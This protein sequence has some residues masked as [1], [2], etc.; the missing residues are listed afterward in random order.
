MR[1]VRTK[2]TSANGNAGSMTAQTSRSD[3]V[4]KVC[5]YIRSNPSEDLSLPALEKWFGVSRFKIQRTFKEIMGI[6][7]RKYAEE[8]RILLLKKNL[9]DNQPIPKAIYQSGYNS[10]SW[11]YDQPSS[12]LG[13][14]PS[15]YRKGGEGA[16]INYLTSKCKLGYLLVAETESGIC[17]LSLADKEDSLVSSLFKEYP[18]AKIVRSESVRKRLDSVLDYFDGQLLSLPVDVTG[19]DFQK[20]VWTALLKIPYGETRSYQDVAKMIGKPKAVRAVANACASNPVS[21]IIP[22]HRV[23][24]KDGGIGGYGLGIDRKEYLL[25]MEKSNSEVE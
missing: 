19:T 21:L 3:L 18:R 1:R 6:S 25:A 17:S 8:C 24:R 15:S 9:K 11:L 14:T 10:H 20:R 16:S 2:P 7:P 23:V 13:M 12:K 4:E 5:N 22:C